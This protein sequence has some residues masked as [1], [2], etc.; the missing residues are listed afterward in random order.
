M[1]YEEIKIKGGDGKVADVNANG[2]LNVNLVGGSVAVE[3]SAEI[4]GASLNATITNWNTP[5]LGTT[6][7]TVGLTATQLLATNTS[8]LSVQIENKSSG[9]TLW[10]HGLSNVQSGASGINFTALAPKDRITLERYTGVLW[11]IITGVSGDFGYA[12]IAQIG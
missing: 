9:G 1:A 6:T 11:G 4:N 3:F 7:V 12:G 5:T 10:L 2:G 8:R